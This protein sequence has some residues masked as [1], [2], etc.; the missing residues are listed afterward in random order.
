MD[1]QYDFYEYT[2]GKERERKHTGYIN[3]STFKP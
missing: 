2:Q 1:I 3:I